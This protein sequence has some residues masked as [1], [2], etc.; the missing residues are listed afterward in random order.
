MR[1]IER[2]EN[3]LNGRRVKLPIGALVLLDNA[4]GNAQIG[5]L[6]EDCLTARVGWSVT[7]RPSAWACMSTIVPRWR[8]GSFVWAF[9][10]SASWKL[11]WS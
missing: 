8:S 6:A 1:G 4:R 3:V 2:A 7:Y 5:I 10:A 9:A 11:T